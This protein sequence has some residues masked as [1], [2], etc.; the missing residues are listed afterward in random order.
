VTLPEGWKLLKVRT[1]CTSC[2]YSINPDDEEGMLFVED[3]PFCGEHCHLEWTTQD[4]V[5]P[6]EAKE[7]RTWARESL[8]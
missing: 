7:L 8:K 2:H 5:E 4:R 3:L 6:E 1:D